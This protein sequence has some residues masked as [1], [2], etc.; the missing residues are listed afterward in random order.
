M[1]TLGWCQSDTNFFDFKEGIFLD[2]YSYKSNQPLFIED[3]SSLNFISDREVNVNQLIMEQQKLLLQLMSKIDSL[4]IPFDR[5]QSIEA[6]VA[7]LKKQIA[8]I[9]Q[10]QNL[11]STASAEE[12]V[13]MTTTTFDVPQDIAI[14]FR[15][16]DFSI[17]SESLMI[18][19]EVM[20]ILT[21]NPQWKMVINGYADDTANLSSNLDLARNRGLEIQR[22][23]LSAG[24]DPMQLVLHFPHP[25]DPQNA[26]KVVLSFLQ[27]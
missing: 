19:N 20:D 22:M 1:T 10:T 17:D 4:Q 21:R 25:S 23:L 7:D 9:N 11:N 27:L 2:L 26:P 3:L 15:K 8:L 16:N 24:I 14:H 13:Y 6:E 5:L 18:L 12:L